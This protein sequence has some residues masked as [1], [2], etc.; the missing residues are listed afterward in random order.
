MSKQTIL[1]LYCK[2]EKIPLFLIPFGSKQRKITP[3]QGLAQH[4]EVDHNDH[5]F[6][7]V[8][9]LKRESRVVRCIT[10]VCLVSIC[11]IVTQL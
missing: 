10:S 3:H 5:T 6:Y 7:I 4:L 2:G 8:V 1:V 9:P 11:N